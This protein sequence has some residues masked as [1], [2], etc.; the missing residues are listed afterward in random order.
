[1]E[2][3]SND[4]H[5]RSKTAPRFDGN[6][7]LTPRVV[8]RGT[9]VETL[10][11]MK[12][13]DGGGLEREGV[14]QTVAALGDASALL[15]AELRVDDQLSELLQRD[16]A[17]VELAEVVLVTDVRFIQQWHDSDPFQMVF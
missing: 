9:F 13:K 17:F 3:D 2:N 5:L 15:A 12:K 4:V 8:P 1:M 11:N 7:V 14:A 16:A 10:K 6:R